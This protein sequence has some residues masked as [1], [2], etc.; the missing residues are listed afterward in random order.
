MSPD[1]LDP[2]AVVLGAL[3]LAAL[4]LAVG[5]FLNVVIHR[6]PDGTSIVRP[7]SA[8]PECGTPIRPRDNVPVVSWL[9]LRG[10]CRTCRAP[11]SLR[12]PL[13]ELLNAALWL[14]L[15]WWAA[16][17]G[18]LALL[19]WLLVL[20]SACVAL[21]FIDLEHHRLP[22]AIVLRLYPVGA[23]GLGLAGLLSGTWPLAAAGIGVAVWLVVIGGVWFVSGGRGMGF[24]DVKL[25]PV[26][27]ATLGWVGVSAAIVGLFSA[28]ALGAIVGI[29]LM[30]A[31]RAGRKSAI[32]F[33]PFLVLGAGVGL[34]LGEPGWDA[35]L[36]MIGLA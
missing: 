1:G 7:A 14:A 23:V 3:I 17:A 29:A 9:L 4:G 35:Y 12:Y 15:G 24:G 10:R 22:D 34:V 11:I 27:G 20:G 32:P 36:S 21:A 26:L 5:S 33:G 30:V 2:T 18:Q 13:V 16:A 6:V 25:A 19:P 28:F 8:C 31:R